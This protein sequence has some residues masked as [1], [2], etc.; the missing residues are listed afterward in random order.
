MRKLTSQHRQTNLASKLL[1]RTTD[2]QFFIEGLK[3]NNALDS[4]L[5]K[6]GSKSPTDK[7]YQLKHAALYS[8]FST[9][10]LEQITF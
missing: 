7:L 1:N 10:D 9:Y 2:E 4:D 8:P 5:T 3:Y 6:L